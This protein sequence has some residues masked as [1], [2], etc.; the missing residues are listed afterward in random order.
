M[1]HMVYLRY[2]EITLRQPLAF[3]G[4]HYLRSQVPTERMSTYQ[5]LNLVPCAHQSVF[6]S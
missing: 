6:M 4:K 2:R 5:C 1:R 3:S